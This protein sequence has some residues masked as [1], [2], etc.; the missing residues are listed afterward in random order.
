MGAP[1][2]ELM[3]AENDVVPVMLAAWQMTAHLRI[4]DIVARH[5]SPGQKGPQA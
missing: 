4:A 5:V 3:D 2:I 1:R